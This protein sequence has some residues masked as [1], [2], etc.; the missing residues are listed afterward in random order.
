[1]QPKCKATSS[2]PQGKSTGT[3]TKSAS[4]TQHFSSPKDLIFSCH[5]DKLSKNHIKF[6]KFIIQLEV[7]ELSLVIFL[8]L[9]VIDPPKY[10]LNKHTSVKSPRYGQY[11]DWLQLPLGF[12]LNGFMA[13]P[14]SVPESACCCSSSRNMQSSRKQPLWDPRT[15]SSW[16]A[17][18]PAALMNLKNI[19]RLPYNAEGYLG[20]KVVN[21]NW[22]ILS[23]SVN[24]NKLLYI[25]SSD[26]QILLLDND[27]SKQIN[28]VE[29][30]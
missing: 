11:K 20:K 2:R 30:K 3:F 13:I 28:V 29:K 17:L 8:F 6:F 18:Y 7:A 12:P 22:K 16:F 21:L 25:N 24:T 10:Y 23:I 1:M 4:R 5:A 15:S 14:E 27:K 9:K 19:I 26:S